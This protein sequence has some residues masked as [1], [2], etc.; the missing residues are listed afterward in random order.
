[1]VHNPH[2]QSPKQ[3]QALPKHHYKIE[4]LRFLASQQRKSTGRILE[5]RA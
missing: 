4:A 1:M 2:Y 5:A 3:E